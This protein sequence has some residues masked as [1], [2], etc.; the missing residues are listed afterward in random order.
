MNLA[1]VFTSND[2]VNDPHEL[3]LLA[4]KDPFVKVTTTVVPWD[5][6]LILKDFGIKFK[7]AQEDTVYSKHRPIWA[8]IRRGNTIL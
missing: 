4:N 6:T 3:L 7:A 2:A 8:N 5:D 1:S